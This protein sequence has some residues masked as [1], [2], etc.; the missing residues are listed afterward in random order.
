[1]GFSISW[2]AVKTDEYNSLFE[3]LGLTQTE[4]EDE[5]FESQFTGSALQNGWFLLVGQGCG[6]RLVNNDTLKELSEFGPTIGCSIEEHVMYSSVEK[7]EYGVEKWSI[8]HYAQKGIY[9]LEASDALPDSFVPMQNKVRSEQDVEG[10]EKAD[11]DLIFDIPLLMAS[12][13]TGFKHDED[14]NSLAQPMPVIFLDQLKK[15]Q[16]EVKRPWWKLW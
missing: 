4:E 9:N 11:V 5:Y 7:W 8:T 1:M 12:E 14:C 10:G 2:I 15:P 6:N 3:L 16:V 13:L